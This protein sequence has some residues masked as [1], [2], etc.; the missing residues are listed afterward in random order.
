MARTPP[1]RDDRR[2]HLPSVDE[3]L[4][5]P[6]VRA[7]E[8]AHG[9][10]ALLRHVRALLAEARRDASGDLPGPA[11]SLTG[12]KRLRALPDELAR[13]MAAAAAPR[14]VGVINATGVVIHTNLG[15]APLPPAAAARVAEIAAGYSNLEFD[16]A[17]G[18]RGLRRS[19]ATPA[20]LDFDHSGLRAIF[21][22]RV[23]VARHARAGGSCTPGARLT[24]WRGSSSSVGAT[25]GSV[26]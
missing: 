5:D 1:A 26:A 14:L 8:R 6:R 17:T 21:G 20:G 19:F 25:N 22:P 10:D 9:R 13:R 3:V 12:E 24:S 11:A 18:G 4:R 2:R 23:D 7:L 16:L 15:R